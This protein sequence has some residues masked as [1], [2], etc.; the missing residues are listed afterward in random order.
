MEERKGK[1]NFQVSVWNTNSL[2][3]SI[4]LYHNLERSMAKMDDKEMTPHNSGEYE[5][6]S[7]S[8]SR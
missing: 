5:A 4:K 8:C 2:L 1:N 6:F 3:P 7:G